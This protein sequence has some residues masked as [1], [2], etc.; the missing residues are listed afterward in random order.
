MRSL[1]KPRLLRGPAEKQAKFTSRIPQSVR[2]QEHLCPHKA[3]VR[4]GLKREKVLNGCSVA[5]IL[6]FHYYRTPLA[7]LQFSEP[8]L[9]FC[10]SH[11]IITNSL[12]TLTN[13]RWVQPN[14]TSLYAK[15][16]F[17]A[18]A[19]GLLCWHSDVWC[20]ETLLIAHTYTT[21]TAGRLGWGT[22][23]L[24]NRRQE[25]GDKFFCLSL[26]WPDGWL[27]ITVYTY[28]EPEDGPKRLSNQSH[29]PVVGSIVYFHIGPLSFSALLLLSLPPVS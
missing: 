14:I 25:K 4:R 3:G 15:A 13:F 28:P 9:S 10:S 6:L 21:Q 22:N 5:P 16:H 19:L 17:S 12:W 24:I 18:T 7:T 23:S 29:V 1:A 11:W 26:P 2:N 27:W 8:H 20:Y